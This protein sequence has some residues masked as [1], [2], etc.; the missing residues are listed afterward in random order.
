[1]RQ[2]FTIAVMFAC[3]TGTALAQDTQS[4]DRIERGRYLAVLGDCAG[5]HTAPGGASFAGGVALKTPFGKLVAPNITP[6]P[7]TG[8]GKMTDNE[9]L[10]VLH[11]GR[12]HG[13]KRLYPAMPYTAYTKMTDDD[14]LAIRAYLGT[15]APVRNRVNSNQLPFPLNIRLSMFFWNAFNFTPGRYQPNLTKSTEWNRGA[16]IVEGAAHCGTCHT[17]KTALGGDQNSAAL[18]GATLQGW[19][20]PDITNDP[21]KGIGRWSQDD[22]VK[23]L[24]TGANKWTLA[25]GPMGEAVSHSTSLMSDEDIAA[26][27]AYLKDSHKSSADPRPQPVAADDTVMHAGAAIYKDNCAACHKDLGKGEV[28]LFPRLAGSA[29]VQSDDSTTLARV[30]LHGN[31]A[32]S[33]SGAPTAPAMPPFDWRLDDAQVAAVLTYIRNSWGNAA[34]RVSANTVESQR[35]AGRRPEISARILRYVDWVSEHDVARCGLARGNKGKA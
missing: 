1:M 16:Y 13:G 12:G 20:A 6:D 27:A 35:S 18:T 14:V 21:R 15:V 5:C 17:P 22:L 7:A 8:I 23:Y 31:R 11:E 34:G 10:A 19:F 25:S 24:K 4:F 9:F 30:V 33:T 28:D 2:P 32:V 29:L 26:I 3:L